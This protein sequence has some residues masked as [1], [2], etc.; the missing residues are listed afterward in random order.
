[1]KLRI[2]LALVG[3]VLTAAIPMAAWSMGV[4]TFWCQALG[5]LV[6]WPLMYMGFSGRFENPL[7]F[8]LPWVIGLANAALF[9]LIHSV[10]G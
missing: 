9:A 6:G 3:V 4:P 8:V 7:R 10:V 5:I 1:M 2:A